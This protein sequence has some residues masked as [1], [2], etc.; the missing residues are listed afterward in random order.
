[1][2]KQVQAGRILSDGSRIWEQCRK[3]GR[4]GTFLLKVPNIKENKKRLKSRFD[5]NENKN[6]SEV[7][8]FNMFYHIWSFSALD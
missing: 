3:Q 5:D 8:L 2:Y 1:M 4:K 7:S 6:I